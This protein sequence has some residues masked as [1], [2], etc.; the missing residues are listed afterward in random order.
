MDV[1]IF[2]PLGVV[3]SLLLTAF[4]VDLIR[5]RRIRDEL[6]IPWLLVAVA[7]FVASVWVR[8]WEVLA[9]WVEIDYAPALVLGAA[10]LVC[11]GL[12]LYLTIVVSRLIEQNLRLAQDL[13]LLERRLEDT[14]A[15]PVGS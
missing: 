9:R 7:P 11:L 3:S 13:A 6:W 1:R 15:R 10:I 5:R 4:V 2:Q 14:R 12:V 8:P